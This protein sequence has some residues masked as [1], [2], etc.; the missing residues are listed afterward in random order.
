MI[1]TFSFRLGFIWYDWYVANAGVS[2]ILSVLPLNECNNTKPINPVGEGQK[3]E[4]TVS[5]SQ[6]LVILVHSS[7]LTGNFANFD[8]FI[9]VG[10]LV[11]AGNSCALGTKQSGLRCTNCILLC[12]VGCQWGD[13]S[14]SHSAWMSLTETRYSSKRFGSH[15]PLSVVTFREEFQ[16]ILV[17]KT[18]T[19]PSY[20]KIKHNV[21]ACRAFKLFRV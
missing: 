16:V 3:I 21:L 15:F 7:P 2:W 5:Y 9:S 10:N 19:Q 18:R 11:A 17:W 8:L 14:R 12:C 6:K 1:Q 20:Q 4:P 13:K